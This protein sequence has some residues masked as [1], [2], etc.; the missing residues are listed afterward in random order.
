[1]QILPLRR[2]A[3]RYTETSLVRNRCPD[4]SVDMEGATDVGILQHCKATG[5]EDFSPFQIL[6]HLIGIY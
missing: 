2:L 5:L 3:Q 6:F 4:G 1:M